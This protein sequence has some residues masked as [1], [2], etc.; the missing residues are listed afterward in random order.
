WLE[1]IIAQE[2]HKPLARLW[3]PVGLGEVGAKLNEVY[4]LLHPEMR[5]SQIC[6]K[7]VKLTALTGQRSATKGAPGFQGV[8]GSS[9]P[10]EAIR[11]LSRIGA[12]RTSAG[13]ADSKKQGPIVVGVSVAGASDGG[14][15]G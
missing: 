10:A 5:P 14:I 8:E 6:S 12:G 3:L 9:I 4:V 1:T 15:R 7:L 13:C 2:H 11:M